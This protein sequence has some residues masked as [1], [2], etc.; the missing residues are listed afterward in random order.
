[1]VSLLVMIRTHVLCINQDN[2]GFCLSAEQEGYI[3]MEQIDF[4]GGGEC[5]CTG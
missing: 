2:E 4:L 5:P 1:M 3:Q